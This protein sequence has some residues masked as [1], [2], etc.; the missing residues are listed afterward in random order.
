MQGQTECLSENNVVAGAFEYKYLDDDI[1]PLKNPVGENITF[2]GEV[3]F[4]FMPDTSIACWLDTHVLGAACYGHT[5]LVPEFC[6]SYIAETGNKVLAVHAAKGST[7]IA[8]WMPNTPGYNMLK[9]KVLA[10]KS[11]AA[12]LDFVDHIYFVWLQGESDAI[13]GNSKTYYKSQITTLA[14]ALK[15]D[16]GIDKFTIIRVGHFTNDERDLEIIAAQDE[17][18]KEHHDFLMLTEM[19]VKLNAVS[20]YMN[21][22]VA[23]HY[24]AKG[25]E[26]LGADAGKALGAW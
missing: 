5:N 3:G 26:K 2:G 21:P 13:A 18:C 22:N 23:G 20:E 12:E 16:L 10:A 15:E 11:K 14:D 7:T 1:V 9:C 25:L 6:R 19:A 17:I 8:Q 4:Y 24:S